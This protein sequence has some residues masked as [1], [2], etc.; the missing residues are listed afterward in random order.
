MAMKRSKQKYTIGEHVYFVFDGGWH[1]GRVSAC[2]SMIDGRYVIQR[3]DDTL[4]FVDKSFMR[5]Q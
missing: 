4:V 3:P 2:P 5:P 1:K